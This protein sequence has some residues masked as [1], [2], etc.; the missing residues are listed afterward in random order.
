M[1]LNIKRIMYYLWPHIKKHW[2]AFSLIFIGYGIGIIF[3]NIT[4]PYLY[5]E[6]ID[7]FASHSNRD[8]VLWNSAV[9]LLMLIAGSIFIQNIGYRIGNYAETYFQS[10]SIK[11]LYD[12][13]FNKLLNHSY[14]FFANNF[15]GSI[16]AKTKRFT[17][18][19]ETFIDVLCYQIFF[20]FVTLVSIL[21]VLF[22]IAPDIAWIF[23]IWALIYIFIT[24]LF[25]RKKICY[26]IQSSNADSK[27]AAFLSDVITNILNVKIFSSTKFEKEKFGN[28]TKDDQD[29][30][31][32]SW[33]FA[34]HQ[35]TV[36]SLL[37]A[38]LQIS[39]VYVSIKM[40]YAGSI[41]V[42]MIVLLQA[43]VWSLLSILWELG[44]ALTK[45]FTSL[46]E[47]QEIVD[48]FDLAPDILDPKNPE[49]LK[50]NSGHVKF[51]NVNF[52][53]KN[54]V[55]IIN[56]FSLEIASGEHVGLVGHS[57]AGKSTITKLLLRFI[58]T[59]NGNITID[60]QNI[61]NITQDDLRSVISYVPQEPILFHRTI[62]ENILYNYIPE[63]LE[64]VICVSDH[65][66][67]FFAPDSFRFCDYSNQL[68][69]AHDIVRLDYVNKNVYHGYAVRSRSNNNVYIYEKD[70]L[71]RE[72][73]EDYIFNQEYDHLNNYEKIEARKKEI[74]T[75]RKELE[76]INK[77]KKDD[78]WGSP[79]PPSYNE[80]TR[81]NEQ[82]I[83]AEPCQ[84]QIPRVRFSLA[85][86]V[87]SSDVNEQDLSVEFDV[88]STRIRME[89][90]RVDTENQPIV[91]E[92]DLRQEDF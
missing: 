58:D 13:T 14:S 88:T 20:S 3:D 19:F 47:M 43:Y 7:L 87:T 71:Y 22:S 86:G 80:T 38:I 68:F 54:G 61:K 62:K 12:F 63:N 41:S 25:I 72:E 92:S 1:K 24:T 56:N 23:F 67:R 74:E 15:S 4:K 70:S 18:S 21:V 55:D 52:A 51:S 16:I 31:I 44:R 57:G 33:N 90:N 5:K 30:K 75:R 29:K 81:Y 79:F 35:Y 65:M 27:V 76:E 69:S 28:K 39:I 34:N 64:N 83:I 36:Q 49:V 37:M 10:R 45:A 46:S 2:L 78:E 8:I 60:E 26:D 11:S 85:D 6:I 59:D 42:G 32:K 17:K 66:G 40:L 91:M 82:T 48:I 89:S 53:Y 9:Q 84:T 77:N 73:L 50:I